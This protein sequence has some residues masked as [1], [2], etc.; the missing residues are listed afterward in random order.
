MKVICIVNFS[1][2]HPD[3]ASWALSYAGSFDE[4]TPVGKVLGWARAQGHGRPDV[5][6]I[7][8]DEGPAGK[9]DAE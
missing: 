3:G 1:N 5:I 7:S 4:A 2:A 6:T 9:S 8:P